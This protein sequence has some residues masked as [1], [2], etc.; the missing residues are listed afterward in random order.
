MNTKNSKIRLANA[1]V[2]YGAFEVTVG[3]DPNVPDGLG[4]LDEVSA[5]GYEGIDLGPVGYLGTGADLGRRLAERNL[6]LAGAYLEFPFSNHEKLKT[7]IPDLDAMLDT[8]DVVVPLINGPKPRP[9]IADNGNPFRNANPGSGTRDPSSGFSEVD[10]ELFGEGLQM[11]VDRCRARGYEP[12]FH[13][14][15][16]TNI[17]SPTEIERMLGVSDVGWCLDTGHFLIGGGDPVPML[18]KWAH[19][20]NHI[21]I[22]DVTLRSFEE[23]VRDQAPT[24]AIWDREIFPVIGGGDLDIKG[25]IDTL[26]DVGFAGWAVVEQDIFPKTPERFK[27]ASDDQRVNRKFLAELGI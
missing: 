3:I 4:I 11:I 27:R 8:F 20:I 22:K 18:S 7:V 26:E 15:T 13:N 17:E 25:L 19:R 12:T 9:T 23:I 1:P 2:S 10:W 16:G 5:A 14:E 6:G 24:T 21:H